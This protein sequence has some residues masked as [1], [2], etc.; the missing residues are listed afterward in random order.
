[1]HGILASIIVSH[2]PAD[3][4]FIVGML[5]GW[6]VDIQ[7][8]CTKSVLCDCHNGG[9]SHMHARRTLV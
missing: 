2:G 1:M 9:E 4:E 7:T 6:E 3:F 5:D 8:H